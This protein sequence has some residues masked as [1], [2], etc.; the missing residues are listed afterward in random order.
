M[1]KLPIGD[2]EKTIGYTFKNKYLLEQAFVRSSYSKEHPETLDNEQLEFYGDEALEYYVT[3]ILYKKFSSLTRDGHFHSEK[4]EKELTEIKS[5]NV[6]TDS[7]AHCI[8]I[9]GFQD[10]LLM[11]QSD[12]KNNVKNKPSVMADLFEAILGAVVVDSQW[13]FESISCY[14]RTM[15][16][17][18]SFDTNYIKWINN[19]CAEN[20]LQ[21]PRFVPR[22]GLYNYSYLNTPFM[23]NPINPYY[24][25][26]GINQFSMLK[27]QVPSFSSM[28]DGA[29]L[30]IL[31]TD[32][33]TE[34]NIRS[35]YA[36]YMDCAK[37]A[38]EIIQKKEIKEAIGT[39][40]YDDA[41][42]QLNILYQKGYVSKPE[43]SFNEEHD[44]DGNPIWECD[45]KIEEYD[46]PFYGEGA[47]KKEAKN[48]AAYEV[49]CELLDYDQEDSQN[50]YFN[51][52][53][54]DE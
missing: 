35:E 8:W 9:T 22:L 19:W 41:V 44:E 1:D 28:V 10:Y 53:E 50:N 38:Y 49:L 12:I 20:G 52:M 36:A 4:T 30:V 45:C 18:L 42:N 54:D 47:L 24:Q 14:C 2:I 33:R 17:L 31:G 3:R 5:Y 15:L 51:D 26:S 29:T 23:G 27:N 39:L 25:T 13:D 6:D 32:I 40:D 37:K 21:K 34:S 48:D 46:E 11:N 7:L 43:Y 16:K